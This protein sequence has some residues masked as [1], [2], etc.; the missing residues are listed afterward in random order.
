LKDQL[1]LLKPGFSGEKGPLYCSDSVAVEGLLGFFPELRAKIDVHYIPAARPREAIV[2][3]IGTDNQSAPVLVLAN[4]IKP[5]D[6]SIAPKTFNGKLFINSEKE[7]RQ[8]LSVQYGVAQ[9][10]D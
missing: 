9:A 8:Y 3:L 5:T 7:I 6:S 10:S 4:G 2:Q 1:F